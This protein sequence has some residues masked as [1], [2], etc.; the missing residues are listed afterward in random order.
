MEKLY[1]EFDKEKLEKAIEKW[2][3]FYNKNWNLVSTYI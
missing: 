1:Y 2:V 3:N